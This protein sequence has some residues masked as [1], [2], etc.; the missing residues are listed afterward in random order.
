MLRGASPYAERFLTGEKTALLAFAV[1]ADR[2][3]ASPDA[4]WQPR[5]HGFEHGRAVYSVNHSRLT[6]S[7]QGDECSIRALPSRQRITLQITEIWMVEGARLSSDE[8]RALGL[9][10]DEFETLYGH[11]M[12]GVRGWLIYAIPIT[13]DGPRQ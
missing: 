9:S 11:Q 5:D 10:R 13:H 1:G 6:T 3:R 7:T 8:I 2:Y 12:P 4:L